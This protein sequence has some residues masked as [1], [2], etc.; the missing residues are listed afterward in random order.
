M[1]YFHLWY[2]HI[3]FPHVIS[4]DN[5]FIFTR[6]FP[7]F[8]YIFPYFFHDSVIIQIII[9]FETGLIHFHMFFSL[10][11]FIIT[12]L[13]FPYDLFS[14]TI[15]FSPDLNIFTLCFSI[16]CIYFVIMWFF[17]HD[18]LI[19]TWFVYFHLYFSPHRIH[20]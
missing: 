7:Q 18:S 8:I 3:Y 5:S 12:S 19:C 15:F 20:I 11:S 1:L 10:V 17:F 4:S 2:F 6:F 9:I 16:C 14:Y 13:S